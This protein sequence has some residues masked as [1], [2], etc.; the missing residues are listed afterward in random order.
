M[1][2]I[3]HIDNNDSN[4]SFPTG[5][6]LWRPSSYVHATAA[7]D[8]VDDRGM[9]LLAVQRGL[10]ALQVI[11]GKL[12][13]VITLREGEEGRQRKSGVRMAWRLQ[14]NRHDY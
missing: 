4:S 11:D 1:H 7:V 8:S 3:A 6:D 2:M 5:D 13:R 9:R 14:H 10:G 12:A